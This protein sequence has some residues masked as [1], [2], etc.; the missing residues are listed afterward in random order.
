M[1]FFIS[2]TY[3]LEHCFNISSCKLPDILGGFYDP[4][5]ETR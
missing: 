3:I 2:E 4:P 1:R 5:T